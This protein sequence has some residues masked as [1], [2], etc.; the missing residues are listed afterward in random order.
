M[1]HVEVVI[2]L[3][4][5]SLTSVTCS[6]QTNT[7]SDK[8]VANAGEVTGEGPPTFYGNAV[9][10]G[11]VTTT[12]SSDQVSVLCSGTTSGP[13]DVS[14]S[15]ALLSAQPVSKIKLTRG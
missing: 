13:T 8:L 4:F 3:T 7:A 10:N 9:I 6:L 12:A 11:T 5:E 14:T 15:S 2:A 1:F